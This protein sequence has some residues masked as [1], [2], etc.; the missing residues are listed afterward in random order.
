MQPVLVSLVAARHVRASVQAQNLFIRR[1][2]LKARAIFA[3]LLGLSVA[4]SPALAQDTAAPV[5]EIQTEA[6]GPPQLRDFSINGTVTRRPTETAEPAPA[7][8]QP[9]RPRAT[10][11]ADAR[12]AQPQPAPRR[13]T[14]PPPR[15]AAPAEPQS[16]TADSQP[17]VTAPQPLPPPSGATPFQD[18]AAP[19]AAQR[20]ESQGT[21]S[22]MLPWLAAAL[23][24]GGIAAWFFLRQRPR[25]SFAGAPGDH[26][27]DVAPD[28]SAP[29]A[30]APVP[31][32]PRA[33]PAPAPKA[34]QE[35]VSKLGPGGTIV[36]TRLRPWLEIEF[37]ARRT[38]VEDNAV[39]V[40]FDVSVFNSG[41]VPAREVLVEARLLNAGPEHLEELR[42]FYSEP[43]ALGSRVPVIEP[44]KRVSVSNAVMLPRAQVQ[45]IE[46]EGRQ[47]L[48]PVVAF[49][50]L[51]SW[52]S[53]RGQTS[54][55][56][57]VGRQTKGEKL[58][59][60]RLDAGA[61]Q[62]GNLAVREHELRVRN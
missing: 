52:G 20:L 39:G 18:V 50:A 11:G 12:P 23:A 25:H 6:I 13:E 36:S 35:P 15:Q 21:L 62:F 31:A 46:L 2:K 45:P 14:P 34:P 49:N 3:A 26:R 28:H 9:A 56:F 4:A 51:Y 59:P 37:I 54:T 38:I 44:L 47:L 1:G 16:A 8:R 29:P 43:V 24:L 17:E 5:E 48:V 19:A 32:A 33:A 27:L 55:G 58:A 41:S 30:P 61:R 10:D 53:G 22:P 57:L 60:F 40:E 7:P 42:R